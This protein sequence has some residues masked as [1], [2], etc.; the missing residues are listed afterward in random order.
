MKSNFYD[1]MIV[2]A[3][4]FLHLFFVTQQTRNATQSRYKAYAITAILTALSWGFALKKLNANNFDII[5]LFIYGLG[6]ACGGIAGILFHKKT[7][8]KKDIDEW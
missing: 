7:T 2:F 6:N 4:S 8:K 5:L 3:L 1:I